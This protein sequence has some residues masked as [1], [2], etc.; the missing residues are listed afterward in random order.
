[1]EIGFTFVICRHP[2]EL[3]FT[4]TLPLSCLAACILGRL[5]ISSC[6]QTPVL[7]VAQ[8]WQREVAAFYLP[9]KGRKGGRPLLRA[10]AAPAMLLGMD[11][12]PFIERLSQ[13]S[14]FLAASAL[15]LAFVWAGTRWMKRR[16]AFELGLAMKA[17][18]ALQVGGGGGAE[19][20]H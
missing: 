7:G 13:P 15:Y 20:G 4:V 16:K 11:V 3:L 8:Q 5:R 6:P 12:E 18:N 17:Y 2:N 1:M 19:L 10:M 9:S 14:I